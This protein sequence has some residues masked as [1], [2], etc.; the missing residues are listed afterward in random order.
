MIAI[1]GEIDKE[2]AISY[3]QVCGAEYDSHITINTSVISG[4]IFSRDED[5]NNEVAMK[6]LLVMY[7]SLQFMPP[8]TLLITKEEIKSTLLL[9]IKADEE[10]LGVVEKHLV[11]K[12]DDYK[13]TVALYDGM[14]NCGTILSVNGEDETSINEKK[15]YIKYFS[16]KEVQNKFNEATTAEDIN[17]LADWYGRHYANRLKT[18]S[19]LQN[20]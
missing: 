10:I 5:F 8:I 4:T 20:L 6:L 14:R 7:H 1:K 17:E 11:T 2:K 13:N 19:I 18:V 15:K 3:A 12:T 9:K 16:D